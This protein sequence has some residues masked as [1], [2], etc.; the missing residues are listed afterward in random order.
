MS[1]RALT[2]GSMPLARAFAPRAATVQSPLVLFTSTPPP[3]FRA[4][5]LHRLDASAPRRAFFSLPDLPSPPQTLT[6]TRILPYSSAD[7]YT[8]VSDVDAYSKF[9]P[10]CSQ[11]RVTKWSDPDP[12]RPDSPKSPIQADLRVGWGGFEETFTSRLRC[13][14][15]Q[16]VEALSGADALDPSASREQIKDAGGAVF[17]SLVTKWQIRPV[18]S[19]NNQTRVDLVIRFQFA[20]PLYAAVS[21]AVSE[22]VAG[23]MIEAFEK[24]ARSILGTPKSALK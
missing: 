1:R 4:Q 13:V 7:L 3:S 8:L 21:A 19:A 17:K 24:R 16:S 18:D 12:S 6:A 2:K 20:N 11:S 22:K 10:Y 14:P 9:V 15:G 23:V 5:H